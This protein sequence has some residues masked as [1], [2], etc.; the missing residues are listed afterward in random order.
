MS[1]SDSVTVPIVTYGNVS[2]PASYATGG[3]LLDLSATYSFI[4]FLSIEIETPGTIL[5]DEYEIALN[6]DTTGAF[7]PGKAVIKLLVDKYDKMS[8]GNVSGNP[9]STTVEA[10]KTATATTTGSSHNHTMNHDHPNTTSSTPTASGV[11][12]ATTV[13]GIAQTTHTHD[14]DVAAYTGNTSSDTH[15]HNRSFEYDHSHGTT[16]GL[17]DIT[18]VEP[19]VGTNFST[20]TWRYF[21]VGD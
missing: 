7:A 2:G 12:V 6:Q 8:V 16:S 1:V 9:A 14:V 11:G 21:A 17:S 3:F 18:P 19:T 4:K 10:S 20:V 5:S 15:T 13:G